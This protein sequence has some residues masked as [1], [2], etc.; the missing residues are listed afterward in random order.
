MPV[1]QIIANAHAFGGGELSTLHLMRMFLNKGWNVRFKPTRSI[2]ERFGSRI[3]E[4]VEVQSGFNS[5]GTILGCDIL[6]YYANNHCLRMKPYQNIWNKWLNVA[7]RKVAVINFK[8]GELASG[9]IRQR[10]DA[11]GFLN[12]TR[13]DQYTYVYRGRPTFVLPP[14]VDLDPYRDIQPNYNEV[15]LIRHSKFNKYS[16]HSGQLLAQFFKQHPAAKVSFMDAPK[17]IKQHFNY[18]CNYY[19][20]F[21]ME[22]AKFLS[23]GSLYWYPLP[24]SVEDQGPRTI[25]E[26]MAAGLPCIAD[27]KDG[28]RDRITESTG[29]LCDTPAGYIE[30]FKEI[31]ENPEL[32]RD[33]GLAAKQRA[34]SEFDPELWVD[35]IIGA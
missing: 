2:C 5:V 10:W 30:V 26:A 12:T 15:H 9:W 8:I 35:R 34:L 25:I 31:K 3:P 21:S 32:L 1:I 29:W 16:P 17:E 20:N 7:D 28:A 33:K 18:R 27:N 14:A 6:L 19:P 23:K 4:G 11:F 13:R 22:P 24:N